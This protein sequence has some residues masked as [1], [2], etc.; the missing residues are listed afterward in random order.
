MLG[1]QRSL[2]VLRFSGYAFQCFIPDSTYQIVALNQIAHLV[3]SKFHC[4]PSEEGC[5]LRVRLDGGICYHSA[6]EI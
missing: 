2:L 4:M 1:D 6:D 3:S 5:H